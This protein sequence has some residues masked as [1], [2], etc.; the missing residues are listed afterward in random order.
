[1]RQ[2]EIAQLDGDDIIDIKGI[3]CIE[4]NDRGDKRLKNLNARRI[5][6]LHDMLLKAGLVEF[7]EKRRG[8]KLFHDIQPYRGKYGHQISKNF[9]RYLER[10]G[11]NRDGQ[12][13]HGLRHSVVTKLWSAGTPEPHV[14]AVLGH[15]RGKSESY[16]RYAK[17]TDLEPL[18]AAIKEIDYGNVI[19]TAWSRF[20]PE[21]VD[22]RGGLKERRLKRPA[23]RNEIIQNRATKE[24]LNAKKLEE[25][26][27]KASVK[28]ETPA[29]RPLP[30][31][32]ILPPQQEPESEQQLKPENRPAIK[33]P[34]VVRR[35]RKKTEE[36]L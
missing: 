12:T 24:A 14:A 22:S 16:T 23:R 30:P 28:A 20:D 10:I 7:A 4:V 17:K 32:T 18:Q 9:A 1:M 3:W 35:R 29:A 8:E 36:A 11:T 25:K 34:V 15:Q 33:K 6:P 2:S 26:R 21:P 31:V 13:F 19:L 27:S 5:I